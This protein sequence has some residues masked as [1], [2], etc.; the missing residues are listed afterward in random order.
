MPQGNSNWEPGD[1]RSSEIRAARAQVEAARLRQERMRPPGESVLPSIPR[2]TILRELHRGGQGVV[3]LAVQDSTNRRVAVKI[4]S[5]GP[6]AGSSDRLARFEREVESLS[7]LKHPNV[8]T[9]HDCG[10]EHGH[11]YLV[12]DYVQGRVLDAYIAGEQSSVRQTLELF[13]KVCDGVNAAHLRGVIHRDLKPGNILVDDRGEPHVLDFGLAK[14]TDTGAESTAAMTETGQFVGSLPWASPEQAKGLSDQLDIRTDVYS[15][16]VVLYQLLIGAFPYPVSAS[17]SETV[18][19]IVDTPPTRPS[20]V[21]AEIDRELE[22]ILLKCLAKETDRRYQNAGEV[23]RDLRRY[24]MGEPIEARRDSLAYVMG[25]QVARFRIAAIVAAAVLIVVS[26]ALVVSIT[27]WRRAEKQR[28]L[29]TLSAVAAHEAA[30]R[31][32]LEADQAR[33]VTEFMRGVLTSVDPDRLGA[34]VRLVQVLNGASIAASQRFGSHPQQ[35]ASVRDLFGQVFSKLALWAE[36]G[37][38]YRRAAELWQG[39]VGP[40]D[41]RT[42]VSLAGHASA[43]LNLSRTAEA[44]AVLQDLVPR[45]EQVFGPEDLRTL[46]VLR[47]VAITHLFRGRVDQAEGMLLKLRAHPRLIEDDALQSKILASLVA[48]ETTRLSTE[49][50][51]QRRAILTRAERM[52]LE[53]IERSTGLQGP[54][55]LTT[56]Q[57]RVKWAEI[58]LGLGRHRA[59]AAECRAILEGSAERLGDCHHIRTNAMLTLAQALAGLGEDAQAADLRIHAIGCLRGRMAAIDPVFMSIASDSL[60]YLERAG[61]AVEGEALARELSAS[62]HGL[63]G[64][65]GDLRYMSEPFV[66]SFVSMQNRLDAAEALYGPLLAAE[67]GLPDDRTRARLHVS[68]AGHLVRRQRF[69]EAERE[70]QK[71]VSGSGNILKGTWDTHPDEIIV[72]FITLYEAWGKPAKA[73]EY[74]QLQR[75]ARPQEE[76]AGVD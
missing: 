29:A 13:A 36:S 53:W 33:E 52:A 4:L 10:R 41:P 23:G 55:G 66:A 11:V 7:L 62:L 44:E 40:D 64:G 28:T 9:I 68:Y 46:A 56:L 38:E 2:Y 24:L 74:R 45:M 61:R 27:M 63:G 50:P 19:H 70:L 69:A 20:A 43:L 71:A 42:L 51:R 34:D 73:A 54:G 1:S 18:R 76:G 65:H 35:E 57:A 31:A 22:T 60:R 8:V 75:A 15:L 14:L 48:V 16:G 26:I 58:C 12:M 5:R 72:A 47:G 3:Y 6:L 37:V 49:D 17:L 32:D 39:A 25:K 21:R 59:A 30:K 67:A